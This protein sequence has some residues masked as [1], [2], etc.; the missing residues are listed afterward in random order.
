MRTAIIIFLH[1]YCLMHGLQAQNE[2]IEDLR[3][4]ELVAVDLEKS[5]LPIDVD[6][7]LALSGATINIGMLLPLSSY[8]PF[9][10]EVIFAAQLAVNEINASGLLLTKKLMLIPA[11]DASE[12]DFSVEKALEL[13]SKYQVAAIVGPTISRNYIKV[14]TK[15]L[16]KYP[17]VMISPAVTSIEITTLDDNDLAFRTIGSDVVQAQKAAIFCRT[18]L[19]HSTA[20]VL[21]I[22]DAYGRGVLQEF[23]KYFESSGGQVIA[24]EGYSSLVNLKD[25]DLAGR[26]LPMLKLKPDVL[27]LIATSN[28][29]IDISHQI[30]NNKLFKDYK[31]TLFASDGVRS[32]KVL[33][34]ANLE[35][36]EGIYCTAPTYLP[37][38]AFEKKFFETYGKKPSSEKIADVYDIIHLLAFAILEGQSTDAKM[39]SSHLR[40]VSSSGRKVTAN[41][42]LTIRKLI[43][44]GVDIDY[45][46]LNSSL[47]FDEHGDVLDR[48]YRIWQI[49][50]GEFVRN[51]SQAEIKQHQK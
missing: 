7:T 40:S 2:K 44:D 37:D 10:E 45:E 43:E 27:F 11:D 46:G 35:V 32:G 51:I 16:P 28:H 17:V 12:A 38:I 31:P 34:D 19:G 30:G 1:F 29:M 15:V 33:T 26:L 42:L 8:R 23:K 24:E 41:D 49:V 21:Y 14:A 47:N 4:D 25:F 6:T 5:A 9:S 18:K 20:A 50:N 48:E 36:F 3:L 22:D 13:T 39:V